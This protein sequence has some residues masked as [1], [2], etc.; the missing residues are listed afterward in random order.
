MYPTLFSIILT[1]LIQICNLQSRQGI[2]NMR[3][4]RGIRSSF[5][6]YSFR[7]RNNSYKPLG[8]GF[9]VVFS[10]SFHFSLVSRIVPQACSSMSSQ[11]SDRLN[12]TTLPSDV[13][14]RIIRMQQESIDEMSFVSLIMKIFALCFA[15][16]YH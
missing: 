3:P 11:E 12:I 9:S 6:M 13:I 8:L 5:E 10:I 16:G 14:R 2:Q 7:I 4:F 15:L 1:Q